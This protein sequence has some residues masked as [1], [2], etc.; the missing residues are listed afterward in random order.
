M[1][2]TSGIL[3]HI[4]SLP[5]P[6]GIGSLGKEAY[7]FV[8]FLKRAGQSY[9]Q[10]LPLGPTGVGDSPY[11]S[12]SIYAGN[13]YFI[14]LDRLIAQGLLQPE[15][16]ADTHWGEPGRVDYGALYE[17]RP[18][19]LERAYR[20]GRTLC[21]AEFAAFRRDNPWV[22]DYG[23]FL[24]LKRK[25]GMLPWTQWPGKAAQ[26][27]EAALAQY[28][29]ELSE[30]I[31]CYAFAQYLFYDQWD[32]LRSYAAEN[33]VRIIGDL[34]IY[35]T[36]DSVDVWKYPE[37]FQLDESRTPI[38][39]AGCPPDAFTA[40]GQLW[41]N[42]LYDWK[43]MER[44][45]FAWWKERVRAAS[46]CFDVIRIDHFRGLES[47]WAVP[48]GDKTARYGSWQPGPGMKLIRALRR[49]CPEVEFIAEDLGFLTPEVVKL[50]VDSGFPGMKVLQ[51][52]FGGDDCPDL[53][54]NAVQNAV[55]YTGT[56]VNQTLAHW[57][58]DCGE[59]TLAFAAAYLGLNE[60]EGYARGVLRGG[61]SSVCSLFVAQLQDW[62]E[63][64]SEARMNVPGELSPKNWS[65]RLTELPDAALADEIYEM[66]ERYARLGAQ[67]RAAQEAL[68]D[69]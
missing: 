24:A 47:Y 46:R 1:K 54:H 20:R 11:Q 50:R 34:P 26:R 39:V 9:W 6:Y 36:V 41:G 28:R 30:D 55:M 21:A 22:E 19:L 7:S 49:A 15:D 42:P 32:K 4:S 64:G 5:S 27:D 37:L 61:M 65:W 43:K 56:H 60:R 38:A 51:F 69:E 53:P 2:R 59:R 40:D 62:L 8:D 16:F 33:G 67:K 3:L 17:Y 12:N 14:D 18:G 13:P 52:A 25:Y 44:S 66:T 29:E 48:Y 31:S 35:V 68:Q 45:R 10:I 63:L 23:L 58:Q 57:L